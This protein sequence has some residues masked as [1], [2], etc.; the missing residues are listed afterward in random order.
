MDCVVVRL[1]VRLVGLFVVRGRCV[2]AGRGGGWACWKGGWKGSGL[3]WSWKG[4]PGTNPGPPGTNPP[5]PPSPGL[6]PGLPPPGC[7]PMPGNPGTFGPDP[8]PRA[9]SPFSGL[10]S[11]GAP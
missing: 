8:R 1:V 10:S 5:G 7:C 11:P 6:K 9:G 2:G 3:R 4:S